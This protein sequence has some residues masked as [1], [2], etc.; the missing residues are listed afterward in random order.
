MSQK[1]K[2][3]VVMPLYN[4]GEYIEET[5]QSLIQQNYGFE[6]LE[7]IIVDDGSTDDGG[8]ICDSYQEKYP[9]RIKVIHKENGGAS[10]ARNVGVALATGEYINFL[11]SDDKL[12]GNAFSEVAKFFEKHAEETDVVTIPMFFFGERDGEHILNYK[13]E[14]GNRVVDL[15]EEWEFP[16]MFINSSFVKASV[17]KKNAFYEDLTIPTNEDALEMLRMLSDKQTMGVMNTTKYYYRRHEGSLV[18]TSHMKRKWYLESIETFSHGVFQYYKNK[19]GYVPKFVQ[20]TIFYEAQWR[21]R[22]SKVG[23]NILTD[24]EIAYYK[25]NLLS[26]CMDIDDDIILNQ[27]NM[28]RENK[29]CLL[30]KKYG[31]YPS[32]VKNEENEW[33]YA[34]GDKKEIGFL[35][36]SI[37]IR[38]SFFEVTEKEVSIEGILTH[39]VYQSEECPPLY[40][41][42][43]GQM[44]LCKTERLPVQNHFLGESLYDRYAFKL[45]FKRSELKKKRIEFYTKIEND[46]VWLD[47]FLI[48]KYFPIDRYSKKAYCEKD[49]V[50][51]KRREGVLFL[52]KR[53][54]GFFRDELPYNL[55]ICMIGKRGYKKA[56]AIRWLVNFLSVIPHKPIW[57]V[58][59]RVLKAG[60][61]GE[62]FFTYLNEHHKKDVNC[63][64]VISDESE[65]FERLKEI[66]KIVPFRSNKHKLLHLLCEYNISSHA[67]AHVDKP[68]KGYE[69]AYRG[70]N[71]SKFIYLDH[72]IIKDDMSGWLNRYNKNIFGFVNATKREWESI[73]EYDYLYPDEKVWLTGKPRFD[74]RYDDRKKIITIMLT[75]RSFLMDPKT[76]KNGIQK[77]SKEFVNSDFYK[78]YCELL[79]NEKLAQAAKEYDYELWVMPHPM[80]QN[81]MDLF[82]SLPDYKI[83]DWKTPYQD[84]YVNSALMLTDYSSAVFD[85]AYLHKPVVYWQFDYEEFFSGKHSFVK[86][87]FDYEKDGF[88]EVEYSLD[89]AVNRIIEYMQ[90]DCKMKEKY[91]ERVDD[92]FSFQDRNNCK[93]LYEKLIDVRQ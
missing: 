87:Y 11:D 89:Q 51:L 32:L 7:V 19:M 44:S 91:R 37:P 76:R 21:F 8:K 20:Y 18:D 88:G 25:E 15:T 47:N 34:Y 79:K 9:N 81:A 26:L 64:F 38:L 17:A 86:G 39:Y 84:I 23:G 12:A 80:L 50:I 74:I 70:I 62:V 52:E 10:S 92:F 78:S 71:R 59:D 72:G 49:G 82:D 36:S 14:E 43:N 67:D 46:M 30:S 75:W 16:Q 22:Q 41:M 83:L 28:Y 29:C 13:Y 5:L 66:G 58:S 53:R 45:S 90:N 24:D 3:S 69:E 56:I 42:I 4:S 65:D 40:I 54:A 93:R 68:F 27:R 33:V 85:F 61:N 60:D 55:N 77:V 1:I 2:F 63:Y 31:Q 73:K 6:N 35:V 48:E 57:L